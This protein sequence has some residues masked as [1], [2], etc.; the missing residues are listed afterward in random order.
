MLVMIKKYLSALF[1]FSFILSNLLY[2]QFQT[3]TSS[4]Y[5][6]SNGTLVI[7]GTNFNV[8]Q[9]VEAS[10]I[11]ISNG[12][13]A[14]PL[15]ATVD[16]YPGSATTATLIVTGNDKLYLNAIL[17]ANGTSSSTGGT[18]NLAASAQWNG[19]LCPADGTNPILVFNYSPPSITSSTYNAR[20]R[21]D[22]IR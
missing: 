9:Y 16:A 15:S 6:A 12:T 4:T 22:I 7:T 8:L 3:I 18:Y 17:D 10:R 1:F 20:Q 2:A 11:Q 5:N 21:P 19:I 13:V 14:R